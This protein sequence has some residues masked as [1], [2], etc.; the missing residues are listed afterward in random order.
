[1]ISGKFSGGFNNAVTCVNGRGQAFQLHT[2]FSQADFPD[3][4]CRVALIF[5]SR[6]Q[7]VIFMPGYISESFALY[8]L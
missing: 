4:G 5:P 3:G 2:T 1:M 8:Y 7:R 6:P